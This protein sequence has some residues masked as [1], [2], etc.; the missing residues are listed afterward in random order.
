MSEEENS[1]ILNFYSGNII[2]K[3]MTLS[4][5]LLP[6]LR[7]P[8]V[9]VVPYYLYTSVEKFPVQG[10]PGH[11]NAPRPGWG[12]GLAQGGR[13]SRETGISPDQFFFFISG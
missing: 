12:A 1:A 8:P 4:G 5:A 11:R 13:S 7:H 3:G 6:P 10:M 2:Q 9:A